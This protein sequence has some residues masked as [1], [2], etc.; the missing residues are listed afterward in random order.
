MCGGITAYGACKTS[1]VRPGQWIVIVGAGGG[2]GHLALQ[3]AKAMGMRPIAVDG[4]DAKKDLC[5]KL[6]AEE[7]LD[8]SVNLYLSC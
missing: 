1:Q 3:Y 8:L 5:L 4:G 6:G 2:L 7:Y